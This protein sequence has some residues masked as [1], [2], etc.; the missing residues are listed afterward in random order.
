MD[1][2][3]LKTG[4]IG[5]P[6]HSRFEVHFFV[7]HDEFE[8]VAARSAGKAFVNAHLRVYVHRW[9]MVIVERTTPDKAPGSGTLQRN[10]LLDDVRDIRLLF[11]ILEDVV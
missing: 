11:Q 8:N 1:G 3:K 9:G 5:N 7:F 6:L 4:R 10:E 2:R